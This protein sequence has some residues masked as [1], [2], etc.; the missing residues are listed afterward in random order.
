MNHKI[1]D[2]IYNLDKSLDIALDNKSKEY[3]VCGFL[4]NGKRIKLRQVKTTS[5][6]SR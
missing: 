6:K 2:F 3:N 1:L 4:L 5:K